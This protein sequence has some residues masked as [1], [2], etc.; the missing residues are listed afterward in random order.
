MAGQPVP[1]LRPALQALVRGP[2]RRLWLVSPSLHLA[3]L[4][5]LLPELEREGA[6]IR[7]LTDLSYRA[8]GDGRVDLAALE[9][10]RITPELRRKSVRVTVNGGPGYRM[11][12]PAGRRG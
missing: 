2:W 10:L 4:H 12:R 11:P 1:C 8:V 5:G 3:A 7:V 9:R 6:E